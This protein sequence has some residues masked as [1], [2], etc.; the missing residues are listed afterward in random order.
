MDKRIVEIVANLATLG[1]Y[2]RLLNYIADP[3]PQSFLFELLFASTLETNGLELSYEVNIRYRTNATVDFVYDCN[4]GTR[5]CFELLSPEMSNQIKL[6]TAPVKTETEGG[7]TGS[8]LETTS[9]DNQN[10]GKAP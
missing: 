3:V 1:R 2:S 4:D 7:S 9:P 10:A 8:A 6:E 5:L